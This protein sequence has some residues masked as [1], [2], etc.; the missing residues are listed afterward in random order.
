MIPC[1]TCGSEC[2]DE[3]LLPCCSRECENEHFDRREEQRYT[4]EAY[5]LTADDRN[6]R[7]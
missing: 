2:R 1:I 5:G 3:Q 4:H 6:D 7:Y